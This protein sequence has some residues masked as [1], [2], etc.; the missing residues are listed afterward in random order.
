MH[1]ILDKI[2]ARIDFCLTNVVFLKN[3]DKAIQNLAE[4]RQAN[5]VVEITDEPVAS[6]ALACGVCFLRHYYFFRHALA[7]LSK[8]ALELV[9]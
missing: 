4:T 8:S 2:K 6:T 1:L 7:L 9:Y 3:N 5:P